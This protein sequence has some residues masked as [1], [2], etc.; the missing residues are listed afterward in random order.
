MNVRER[1][2]MGVTISWR[3]RP[4]LRDVNIVRSA[5]EEPVKNFSKRSPRERILKG[6]GWS[7]YET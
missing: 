5:R 7:A 6:A 4:S 3:G 1:V 2:S